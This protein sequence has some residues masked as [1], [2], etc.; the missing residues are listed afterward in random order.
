MSP[1][2]IKRDVAAGHRALRVLTVWLAA[3][4]AAAAAIFAGLAAADHPATSAS[5]STG[6]VAPSTDDNGFADATAPGFA[7]GGGQSVS[8]GS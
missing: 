3:L 7:S 1:D 6:T 5:S 4:A 2:E 8:G